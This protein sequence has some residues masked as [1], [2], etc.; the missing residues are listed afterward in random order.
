MD[1]DTLLRLARVWHGIALDEA[2]A[3][4]I[5][6]FLAGVEQVAERESLRH[7]FH[8]EPARY[9]RTLDALAGKR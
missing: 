9:W 7:D 4:G 6:R 3:E 8:D 1:I 5:R 2:D